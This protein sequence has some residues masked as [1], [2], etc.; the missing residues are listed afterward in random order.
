[1]KKLEGTL[2]NDL[3]RI[4]TRSTKDQTLWDMANAVFIGAFL[5][6]NNC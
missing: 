5:A 3:H 1:M 4:K 6:W 2:E